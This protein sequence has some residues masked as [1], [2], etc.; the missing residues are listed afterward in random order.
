MYSQDGELATTLRIKMTKAFASIRLKILLALFLIISVSFIIMAGSLTKLLSSYL[1]EQR[2]RQGK[3]GLEKWA[4]QLAE[5]LYN[6]DTKEISSKI[7]NASI[8]L[9]GRVML[10][11]KDAK[12]QLDSQK[13]LNGT[14]F[15]YPE[16]ASLLVQGK[17]SDFG[18]HQSNGQRLDIKK[19]SSALYG[20]SFNIICTAAVVHSSQVIGVLVLSSTVNEMMGS[21]ELLRNE[22]VTM[23]FV[24]AVAALLLGMLI[25]SLISKPIVELT[26]GI[27][28]MGKGDF[29][30]RVP[31][32]N[33]GGEISD[34]AKSFNSMS[35]RLERLE[36]SRNQFVSDASH[37][38]KTPLTS[39]KIL[40]E[41]LIDQ[42][43]M[44]EEL[45]TEFLSDMNKEIDRLNAV[46]SDL[47]SLVKAD[48]HSMRLER[49]NISLAV[50]VK[51][52]LHRLEPIINKNMQTLNF[53]VLD[54][55]DIYADKDKLMQVAFN[56]IE[57]ASKYTQ[58]EGTIEVKVLKN[59]KNAV[60]EVKDNGPGIASEHIDSI[61]Q[62][63]Y[64]VDKAR[65][66][67][68]GGTGL[69]LSISKQ[70]VLLHNGDIK[71]ESKEGEGTTFIVSL[72]VNQG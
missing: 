15:D 36:E 17:M 48:S 62:R 41:S 26:R 51:D 53:E 2:I 19:V 40:L 28:R 33:G 8:E 9:Q 61:F 63:F 67:E 44:E 64:R 29:S 13:Q 68:T 59:G 4:V 22:M 65:S 38:L 71:V 25:S 47:L 16:V 27:Q 42:P 6:A 55:C 72:P 12:V 3:L 43:E 5:P 32:R 46:I 20:S 23:F 60:L 69:G 30:A 66:R 58:K 37:E 35:E 34:M 21:V 31:V 7:E 57:N 70:I 18:I 24:V 1:F 10:L 54:S 50:L 49:E 52:V 56:I 14:R 11:D 39:M 45:R